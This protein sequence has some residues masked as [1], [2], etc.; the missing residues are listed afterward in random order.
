MKKVSEGKILESKSKFGL[1]YNGRSTRNAMNAEANNDQPSIRK[2]Y[3][4][5]RSGSGDTDKR[6]SEPVRPYD[7]S[8]KFISLSN[9]MNVRTIRSGRFVIGG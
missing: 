8:V 7:P 2:L 9:S 4:S 6:R 5:V 1:E 3:E